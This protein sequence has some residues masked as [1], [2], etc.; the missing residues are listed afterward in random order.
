MTFNEN[1]SKHYNYPKILFIKKKKTTYVLPKYIHVLLYYKSIY[2]YTSMSICCM[3]LIYFQNPT[4]DGKLLKWE[5]LQGFW[6]M[7]KIQ[8][9]N[10][11]EM[12]TELELIRQNGWKELCMHVSVNTHMETID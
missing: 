12:F 5:D 8:V 9:D 11:E 10:V 4:V 2:I 3:V 6:D 7:I 1:N